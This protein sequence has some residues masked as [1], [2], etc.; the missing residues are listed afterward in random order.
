MAK[1]KI[2]SPDFPDPY[3]REIDRKSQLIKNKKDLY[4]N[5]FR[6]GHWK[7]GFGICLEFGAWSLVLYLLLL[8]FYFCLLPFLNRLPCTVNRKPI[9]F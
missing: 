1:G 9:L 8:P 4:W 6:F 3:F 5:G 2:Y 7:L